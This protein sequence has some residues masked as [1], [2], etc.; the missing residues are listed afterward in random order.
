MSEHSPDKLS[1]VFPVL[2][3]PFTE[4]G[5]IDHQSFTAVLDYVLGCGA[6][7]VVFPGLASEYEHLDK[8]ERVALGKVVGAR[9]NGRVPFVV[10]TSAETAEMAIQYTSAGAAAGA[11]CAMV[12][13]PRT[14]AGNMDAML[15][16]FRAVSS[17][18]DLPIMLQNAP[19]PIGAELSIEETQAV[20]SEVNQIQYVKEETI[21]CGQRIE[22]LLT[23]SPANLR[24][25][26]GGGGGRYIIDELNRSSLGTFP[27][28]ELTELHVALVEA[29]RNNDPATARLIFCKML[30]ILNMQGVYRSS[31]TK[32]VLL[33]R[34]L[35][36]SAHV[37]A[38]GPRMDDKDRAEMHA[39][40]RFVEDILGRM[41]GSRTPDP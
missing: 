33:K 35:I 21:P 34:G 3:T 15:N 11:V 14:H 26:F 40:W 41:P 23:G 19:A 28:T 7:G 32:E 9:V 6:D 20:I 16:F 13:A 2:P 17:A 30:P 29:Y 10:G 37:R 4:S 38:P 18:A 27:A 22:K 25:V 8:E 12:M 5:E 39:L 31:L 36:G 24:G 1:G